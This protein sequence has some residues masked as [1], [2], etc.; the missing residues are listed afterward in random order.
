MEYVVWSNPLALLS[1]KL[2]KTTWGR[3]EV[4]ISLT[5]Y[6]NN[7]PLV[8]TLFKVRI[9]DKEYLLDSFG[10]EFVLEAIEDN[11]ISM[12]ELINRAAT[13]DKSWMLIWSN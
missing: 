7:H 6:P 13:F 10:H 1:H 9:N 4:D 2:F 8:P 5:P 11:S 3:N 12:G